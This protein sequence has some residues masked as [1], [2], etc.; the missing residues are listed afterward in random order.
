MSKPPHIG[1]RA[2]WPLRSRMEDK[3]SAGYEALFPDMIRRVGGAWLCPQWVA[4]VVLAS[5]RDV[6]G[7]TGSYDPRLADTACDT[8]VPGKWP[9][10]RNTFSRVRRVVTRCGL[11]TLRDVA[12]IGGLRAVTNLVLGTLGAPP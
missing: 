5:I 3:I 11:G 6:E 12:E 1:S 10:T 7:M 9:H 2:Y 8:N 4:V